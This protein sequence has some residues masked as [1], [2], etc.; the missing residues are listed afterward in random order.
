[1]IRCCTR[2]AKKLEERYIVETIGGGAADRCPLCFQ[3]GN[4]AL[5]ELTPR[6]ARYTRRTGGGEREKAGGGR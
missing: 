4:V 6:K 3:T 5:R 1:M 2:C